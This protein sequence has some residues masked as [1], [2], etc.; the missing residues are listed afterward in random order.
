MSNPLN[1]NLT[2]GGYRPQQWRE[3]GLV[4]LFSIITCGIYYAWWIYKVSQEVQ[5]YLGES[6][7]SPALEVVLWTLT[8]SIYGIYWYWKYGQ[9]IVQMQ[10]RAGLPAADNSVLY[11][12]LDILRLGSVSGMILQ[13]Q[14]N[15]IWMA[16]Q[17]QQQG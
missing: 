13:G 15:D 9:K 4:L 2:P 8:C 5:E 6:D 10:T 12:I 3:P 11:V 16:S 1:S 7:L 17:R 14:L